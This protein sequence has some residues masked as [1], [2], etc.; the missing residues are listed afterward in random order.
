M[1][2]TKIVFG[3]VG[4]GWRAGCFLE[5]ARLL[6]EKFEVCGVVTRSD[7]KKREITAT[8]GIPAFS[9]V[10]ELL[11]RTAPE[12][13]V[14]AVTKTAAAGVLPGL[15]ATGIPVLA[16]TPPAAT[17]EDLAV[18]NQT[19]GSKAKVQIA[20]QYHL[21]PLH[22]AALT[23]VNSGW[24]GEAG[25]A[26]VSISHGYHGVSLIR[27]A[28]GVGFANATIQGV[29]Y[30][31][32]MVEGPGRSGLP[33]EEKRTSASHVLA[34]VD[35]GGKVGLYDFQTNQHR[36]W[37]RSQRFLVRGPRGEINNTTL[38]Y[39]EDFR[40]PVE[41][42]LHRRSAGEFGNLEGYH[43]VG[44]LA[45]SSWVY[46]NPFVPARYSDEEIAIASCLD[47][48]HR[49][50]DEGVPFYSLAEASQDQYLALMI[51]QAV[52][53]GSPVQTRTQIWAAPEAH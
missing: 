46:R 30:A 12:F 49:Y 26:H 20:E 43:L 48:M 53:S 25:Y 38:K 23:I 3:V 35:F 41:L 32:P 7:A 5:V 24:L 1:S 33:A 27:K 17:V 9:D 8:W 36:S 22:A 6:P 44:I 19:L 42:S 37:V 50:V 45:G 10:E 28:L 51:E 2:R 11:R 21:Q 15:V 39:L 4:T 14:M 29:E 34:T 13:V 47:K 40:T 18:L 52:T 31:F 16:E